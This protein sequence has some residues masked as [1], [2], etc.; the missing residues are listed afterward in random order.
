MIKKGTNKYSHMDGL[1]ILR[2]LLKR[3]IMVREFLEL[4]FLNVQTEHEIR[5]TEFVQKLYDTANEFISNK[6]TDEEFDKILNISK[7][8]KNDFIFLC[9]K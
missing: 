7:E 1:N 2:E 5:K 3:S 8:Q 9:K 4:A 6:L